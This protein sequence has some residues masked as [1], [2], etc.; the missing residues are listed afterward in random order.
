MKLPR[1]K[2]KMFNSERHMKVLTYKFTLGFSKNFCP[3]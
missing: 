1:P 3:K 2:V